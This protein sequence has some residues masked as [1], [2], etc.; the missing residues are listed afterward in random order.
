MHTNAV[1]RHYRDLEVIAT[2]APV[3]FLGL[4]AQ[5]VQNTQ[6]KRQGTSKRAFLC[7]F[8]FLSLALIVNELQGS[9]E[10]ATGEDTAAQLSRGYHGV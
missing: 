4:C 9:I 2:Q 8:L 3:P 7:T 5:A 10:G 1:R 6:V